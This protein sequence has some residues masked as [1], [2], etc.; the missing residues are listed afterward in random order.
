MNRI[1]VAITAI[2]FTP[3]ST[4]CAADS[5]N[6]ELTRCAAMTRDLQR[7]SCYDNLAGTASSSAVEAL[8]QKS[9]NAL[10]TKSRNSESTNSPENTFGLTGS[11][12]PTVPVNSNDFGLKQQSSSMDTLVSSIPGEFKGFKKG[13]KITLANGQVW[14]VVD[15]NSL[16][17]SATNPEISISKG[18]FNSYRI[19]I[20]GLNK[21]ARVVRIK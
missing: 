17:H 8:S 1:L 5:L 6:S 15:S 14:K 16:F 10:K 12:S 4:L 21:S 11:A 18:V 2:A 7:L 3:L 20:K 9:K 13:D 19:S